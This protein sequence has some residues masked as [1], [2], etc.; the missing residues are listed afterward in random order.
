[1]KRETINEYLRRRLSEV[2]GHHNRISIETGVPQATVSRI[3][4]GKVSPTL[5]TAQP[6][7]DWFELH[8]RGAA[9]VRPPLKRN[10]RS[11]ATVSA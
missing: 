5:D 4:L 9:V 2:K 10:T 3:Y 1:M 7:L 6:L 8:D 11:S